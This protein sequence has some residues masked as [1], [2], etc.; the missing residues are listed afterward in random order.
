MMIEAMVRQTD[1]TSVEDYRT[2][3]MHRI[4]GLSGFYQITNRY[5]R[6]L[7]LP[8]LIE[9]TMRPLSANGDRSNPRCRA[10]TMN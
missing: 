2:T 7:G 5:S 4:R 9:H 10:L 6:L 3:L 1:S 8:R